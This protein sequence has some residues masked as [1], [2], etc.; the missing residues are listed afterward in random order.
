MLASHFGKFTDE[1]I[2]EFTRL[3]EELG[4]LRESGQDGLDEFLK[5]NAKYHDRLV[6]VAGSAQLTDAFRRLGIGTVWREA[7]SGEEWARQMDHSHIAELTAALKDR[8]EARAVEGPGPAHLLRQAS[9]P[10]TSLNATAAKSRLLFRRTA[11]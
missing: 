8:D 1:D 7:L 6:N 4:L 10:A 3:T 11:P 2:A 9:W 5:L